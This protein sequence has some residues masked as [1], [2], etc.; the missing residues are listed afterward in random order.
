[1]PKESP[2]DPQGVPKGS[3]SGCRFLTAGRARR[4][5]GR[6]A[7]TS[8]PVR[9]GAALRPAL[10]VWRPSVLQPKS[11]VLGWGLRPPAPACG[12]RGWRFARGWGSARCAV[13]RCRAL[14]SLRRLW[15]VPRRPAGAFPARLVARAFR[16][17][18][19][20]PRGASSSCCPSPSC[21]V[22][23]RGGRAR[24]AGLFGLLRAVGAARARGH[25]AAAA[26]APLGA[27]VPAALSFGWRPVLRVVPAG[28]SPRCG[29]PR[30]APSVPAPSP[31]RGVPLL[32]AAGRRIAGGG[33][34]RP[35][36]HLGRRHGR[37]DFRGACCRAP[38]DPSAV[39]FIVL[40][41][42]RPRPCF[43]SSPAARMPQS[44]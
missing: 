28:V 11:A 30:F 4:P 18:S 8:R 38:C 14:I 1:M 32:T 25:A 36:H 34:P 43:A 10:V 5:C 20:P 19:A 42:A 6:G 27:S 12:C 9:A 13:L 35:P 37:G 3:P 16:V 29:C 22:R 33:T 17:A 26:L 2:R 15:R 40:P 41:A 24:R 39:F 23:H 7:L 31:R 21:W 44:R